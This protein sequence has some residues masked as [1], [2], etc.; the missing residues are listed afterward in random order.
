MQA[1]DVLRALAVP[2]IK[3]PGRSKMKELCVLESVSL[4]TS[5]RPHHQRTWQR[6]VKAIIAVQCKLSLSRE[7]FNGRRPVRAFA[8]LQLQVAT[9]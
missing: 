6:S 4:L 3:Q 8:R 1:N 2:K 5:A 7:T 9:V